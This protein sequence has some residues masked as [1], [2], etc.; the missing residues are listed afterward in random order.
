[1]ETTIANRALVSTRTTTLCVFDTLAP[2]TFRPPDRQ[3]VP[4]PYRSVP[5]TAM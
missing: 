4:E 5:E 1:M 2:H 3:L